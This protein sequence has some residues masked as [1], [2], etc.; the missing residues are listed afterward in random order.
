MA[1]II[2]VDDDPTNSML[3]KMILEMDGYDVAACLDANEAKQT[4]TSDTELFV[5]DVNLARGLSGI[6]LLTTIRDGQT[7]APAD[8]TVIMTS[9]D[10]RRE[11]ECRQA[12][13]DEFL[14]KPYKPNILSAQIQKLL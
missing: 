2:V 10:Y 7:N 5:I 3:M 9:G 12:G 4:I 6:D 14:L 8:V 11:A 13:A 1:Q